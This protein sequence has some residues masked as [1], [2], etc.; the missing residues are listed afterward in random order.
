MVYTHGIDIA[1]ALVST[2]NAVSVLGSPRARSAQKASL[3]LLV[4][5]PSWLQVYP[6]NRSDQVSKNAA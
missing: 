2:L 4:G 6:W 1:R 3:T 5:H